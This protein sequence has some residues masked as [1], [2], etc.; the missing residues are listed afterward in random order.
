MSPSADRATWDIPGQARATEL[1]RAAAERGEVGH[2]WAFTG[3]PGVG[4]QEAARSLAATLNG[5]HGADAARF[6]RGHH[7]A[8]RE[9]VPIG[10]F[11]RVT[12]V[13]EEWLSAAYQ[14]LSEGTWKVLR[15]VAAERMN[16]QAANAF[17]K[18]L[19][20]PPQRC[21]WILDLADPAEVPDTVLSRCRVLRFRPWDAATLYHRAAELGLD[22]D[23]AHLA[24]RIASGSPEELAR[25][26]RPGA[27]DA[28]REHRSVLTRVR[29]E[30]PG[31][32][33]HFAKEL[34]NEVK[35][36]TG[37]LRADA[38]RE[39]DA[40]AEAYGDEPPTVVRKAVEERY[41]RMERDAK[42]TTIQRALDDLLSWCRDAAMVAGGGD[43][44]IHADAL[45]DLHED[46]EHLDLSVFVRAAD[47]AL[48][49]R[50]ALE[51]NVQ[52]A[53]AVEALVLNI[54]ALTVR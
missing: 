13:R 39:L 20:E 14:T 35:A 28:V 46:V 25:L 8:Y 38:A 9:Y 10:A 19:E 42:T 36:V 15:I 33:L 37:E 18:G 26:A 50:D 29:R 27:L 4:Q 41:A 24:V 31:V 30:G 54:H 43:A 12:D 17:L 52:P 16:D 1:L 5:A 44:V 32:A 47:L 23:D 7:P 2:A 40:L 6:M 45:D 48:R 3:P 53:L 34:D 21:T 22:G 51:V 49:T 11:H